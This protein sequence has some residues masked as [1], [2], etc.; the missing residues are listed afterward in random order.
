VTVASPQ[1]NC[2][3]A[4]PT[5]R[6]SRSGAGRTWAIVQKKAFPP[7]AAAAS[8]SGIAITSAESITQPASAETMT[9]R[10]IALGTS[11]AAPTVSSAAWAEASNPVI[12]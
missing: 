9:A 8:R 12:V 6:R 2:A 3:A 10:T 1:E 7:W 5:R 11:I 4:M